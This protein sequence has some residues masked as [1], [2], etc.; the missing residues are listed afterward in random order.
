MKQTQES[1]FEPMPETPREPESSAPEPTAADRQAAELTEA[2]KNMVAGLLWCGGGLAVSFLTYFLASQGGGRYFVAT[3]AIIWGFIQACRGLVT[4]LKIKYRNGEYTAFWRMLGAAVCTVVAIGWLYTFSSRLLGGETVSY[5]DTE[6]VYTC[7]D[8][9]IRFTV[10]AGYAPIEKVANPETPTSYANYQ[11]DTWNDEIGFVVEGVANFIPS[12]TNSIADLK[13]Y[14]ARRDSSYYDQEIIAPTQLITVGGR[15]M[16][17]SEG[18]S[19]QYPGRIY[20]IYDQMYGQ[21]LISICFNYDESAYGKRTTR[22]RIENLLGRL[23]LLD[24]QEPK[25]AAAVK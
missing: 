22:K 3:G 25:T 18:R 17:C 13:E 20:T 2:R 5:L 10:P 1:A 21:T 23:E 7:V 12:G 16:L 24:I 8:I 6:Q 4:W 19:S 9:G 14:C 15:E 11:M